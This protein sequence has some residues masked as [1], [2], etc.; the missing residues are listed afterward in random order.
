M[1]LPLMTPQ[2]SPVLGASH[3][4]PCL[5]G[6]FDLNPPDLARRPS[7]PLPPNPSS[8]EID[9]VGATSPTR[10]RPKRVQVKN[11]CTNCQKACKKCSDQRSCERCIKVRSGSGHGICQR[12]RLIQ[13]QCVPS[14]SL[15]RTA[16][17]AS[18]SRDEERHKRGS[19]AER[20]R[21]CVAGADQYRQTKD[22]SAGS[23]RIHRECHERSRFGR[24]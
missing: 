22:A 5:P 15:S 23:Q 13:S 8:S 12:K 9:S 3:V 21:D 10:R 6:A 18:E 24:L 20:R 2:Q 7:A 17:I 14:S 16:W 11:A 1:D 4:M 19:S